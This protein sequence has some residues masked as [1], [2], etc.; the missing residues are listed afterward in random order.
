MNRNRQQMQTSKNKLLTLGAILAAAVVLL[1]GKAV[2]S[3]LTTMREEART[4]VRKATPAEYEV[5]RIQ[6]LSADMSKDVLAFS[7]R[8]AEIGTSWHRPTSMSS[9]FVARPSVAP[10]SRPVPRRGPNRPD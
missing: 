9:R 7:D 3:H 8:I 2:R 1:G 10:R 6:S 5:K 4:S